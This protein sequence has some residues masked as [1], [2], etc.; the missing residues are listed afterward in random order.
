MRGSRIAAVIGHNLK[1]AWILTSL[2][3]VTGDDGLI[4][5]GTALRR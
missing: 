1:I 4:G 3:S 5:G 2:H